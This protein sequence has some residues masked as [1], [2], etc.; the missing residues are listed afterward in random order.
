MFDI[1]F[2]ALI[3]MLLPVKLRQP[4]QI[5]W[6]GLVL[7]HLNKVYIEFK[8]LKSAKLYD[9]NFTGQTIYLNKKLGDMF[10][11][12]GIYVESGGYYSPLYLH[13]KG[14]DFLSVYLGNVWQSGLSY[15]SGDFVIYDNYWY[16]YTGAGNGSNP[17]ADPNAAMGDQIDTFVE[18]SGAAGSG[19]DFTVN[20]PE[21]CFVNLSEHDILSLKKTIGYYKLAEMRYEIKT[22]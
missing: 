19:F 14:E 17:S 9:I 5:S 13:N 15:V 4:R 6:L 1:D 22:F 10:N 2:T 3:R 11:C 21:T 7:S 16:G 20:I 12:P 8:N 18:N